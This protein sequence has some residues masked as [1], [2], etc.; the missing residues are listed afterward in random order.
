MTVDDLRDYF[1]HTRHVV[2][3]N[4]AATSP[5][6]RPV[7]AAIRRYLEE[8]HETN[9]ENFAD[10]QPVVRSARAR[11]AGVL[12]TFVD[13]VEF[14]PNT[15][16]GLNVVAQGL[17][18]R[19]GDRVAVPSCEFPANVYPFLNLSRRGVEVDFIPHRSGTIEIDD[20]EKTLRAETRLLTISWVQYLSGFR[21][22]LRALSHLCRERGVLLCV[23][24]IQGVGALELNVEETG[25]D[26]LA[27]GGHK[28]V[29]AT[30]GIGFLYL[31]EA[32]Q[33]RIAPPAGWLHGPIDWDRLDDYELRFHPDATRFRLG[34]LNHVGIAA[35]DAALALY[36]RAG[37]AWC[38]RQ[39]LR[40]AARLADGLDRLGL[41]RYGSSDPEH[42]S[43]IVTV[44]YAGVEG[45]HAHLQDQGIQ[46]AVRQK[47]LRFSPT[48]YNSADEIDR[49]LEAVA[50][51]VKRGGE[52]S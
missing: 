29:M 40:R 27:C 19:P 39:V 46:T 9:V 41:R 35:L 33:E 12:G 31:T 36:D 42:A 49:T 5:L 8:R 43:G 38:G 6:S 13:R 17:D 3:L 1:P 4:H 11:A 16:Y 37:P 21:V 25:I 23:D 20:V 15:S 52:G 18:W 22:D 30:Q 44:E 50:S 47:K 32:L 14:A 10:F 7:V 45:L 51:F 24:A 26:F 2:Y 34:T 48:Y 28:W